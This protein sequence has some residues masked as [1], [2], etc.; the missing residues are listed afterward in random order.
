MDAVTYPTPAVRDLLGEHFVRLKLDTSAPND[1]FPRVLG[2]ERLMWT[3]TLVF[4]DQSLRV[5]RR[6]V[7]FRPPDAFLAELGLVLGLAALQRSRPESALERLQ[8]VADRH[9]ETDAAAE[10]LYWAGIAAFR[11]A[12]RDKTALRAAWEPLWERYPESTWAARSAV[13]PDQLQAES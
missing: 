3:P 8:E 7:G 10:S 2:N 9:P 4:C 1:S 12:G 5:L 11:A 6:S 13:W